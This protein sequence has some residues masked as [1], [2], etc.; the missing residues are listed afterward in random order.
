MNCRSRKADTRPYDDE[1]DAARYDDSVFEDV[2]RNIAA[3]AARKKLTEI[4]TP[5]QHKIACLKAEGYDHRE[6]G[7]HCGMSKSAVGRETK[8]ARDAIRNRAPELLDLL[9][10]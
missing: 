10:A 4:L 2:G 3:Q 5:M 7:E 6:I 1:T 8:A 9:A